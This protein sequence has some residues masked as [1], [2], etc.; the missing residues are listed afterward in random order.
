MVE[1]KIDTDKKIFFVVVLFLLVFGIYK[2]YA[3]FS[4]K[5][6]TSTETVTTAT[7]SVDVKN[8]GIINADNIVPINGTDIKTKATKIDFTVNN[9]GTIDFTSKI[10]LNILEISDAL[11]SDE[12]MWALYESDSELYSGDFANSDSS[13][14]LAD[15]ID[16]L[17]TKSR[18]FSLYIWIED[19]G[20]AQ[21]ELQNGSFKGQIE[22]NAIQ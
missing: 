22:V 21:D 9:T 15:D 5:S 3:Y 16:I 18:T 19:S 17:K 1:A 6:K 11:R 4:S 14:L 2:S 13:I 8:N 10:D 7:L 12:F 20:F